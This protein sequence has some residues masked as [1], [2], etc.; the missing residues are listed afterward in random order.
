MSFPD[1]RPR[2]YH[3]YRDM[4]DES[5]IMLQP[6]FNEAT[7]NLSSYFLI[8]HL[9]FAASLSIYRDVELESCSSKTN[10]K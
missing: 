4:E 3:L 2:A 1:S 10:A 5:T 6:F 8:A 9:L 7:F